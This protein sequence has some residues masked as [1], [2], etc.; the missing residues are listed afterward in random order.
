MEI[1]LEE[2]QELEEEEVIREY[3]NASTLQPLLLIVSPQDALVLKWAGESGAAMHIVL[4]SH[5]DAGVRLPDTEA[6]TMQYM[7]DRFNIA[8]PPGLNYGIEDSRLV[9]EL[10]RTF[11]KLPDDL[12]NPWSTQPIQTTESGA[13]PR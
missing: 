10:E 2:G 4:R 6:V 9:I 5:D 1:L 12:W 13:P 7:M 8:M 11:L 3:L